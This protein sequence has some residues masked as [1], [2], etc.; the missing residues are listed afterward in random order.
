MV[1]NIYWNPFA[2]KEEATRTALYEAK[3]K[4]PEEGM[5]EQN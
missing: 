4:W 2:L 1:I 5:A 3:E